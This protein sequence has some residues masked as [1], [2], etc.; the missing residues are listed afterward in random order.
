MDEGDASFARELE[1]RAQ[2]FEAGKT[3]AADWDDVAR[4]LREALS[5]KRTP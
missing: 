2:D 4:R 5:E 3:Q 1:R